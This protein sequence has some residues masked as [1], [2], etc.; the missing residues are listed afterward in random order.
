VTDLLH[1]P[2]SDD[3]GVTLVELIIYIALSALIAGL[4]ATMF[5]VGLNSQSTTKE[6]DT[7]TGK[8]QTVSDLLTFSIRNA[9]AFRV[10]GTVLRARV[11]TSGTS[12]ECRAWDVTGGQVRYTRSSS[13]ITSTNSTSW[14][15]LATGASGT[16]TS[17]APFAASG[18]RLTF[19]I[20]ISAGGT[21]V[22]LSGGAVAQ[23]ASEG[24]GST[25]W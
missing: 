1:R 22:P 6:A 25:C 2:A 7:A 14:S 4:M 3:E 20:S 24:S 21:A 11:G 18:Q 8:A 9:T 10:D 16:L 23:A 5:A 19:G 15:V 12:Y 17:G 13:A